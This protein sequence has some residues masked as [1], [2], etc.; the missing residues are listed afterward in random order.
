[1]EYKIDITDGVI[2]INMK[3]DLLGTADENDIFATIQKQID[4]GKTL[5]AAE[6]SQINYMN[7]TGLSV[8]IRMLT[9]FRNSGGEM[10][11]VKP[12]QQAE[13]LLLITKLNSIFTTVASIEAAV[14]ELKTK[15]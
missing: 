1:M 8:L 10:L 7:S 4:E 13:K 14:N 5:C 6:I 11:L 3:G 15:L 9:K 2:V 12:S